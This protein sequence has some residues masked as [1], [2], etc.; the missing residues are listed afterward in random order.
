M[1]RRYKD[2]ISKSWEVT[3]SSTYKNLLLMFRADAEILKLNLIHFKTFL[4]T[5]YILFQTLSPL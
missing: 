5:L 1:E 2:A 4:K 3:K